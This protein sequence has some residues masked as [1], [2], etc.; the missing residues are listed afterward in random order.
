M[1]GIS[2][3]WFYILQ[4]YYSHWLVMLSFFT[5]LQFL[6]ICYWSKHWHVFVCLIFPQNNYPVELQKI[7][8]M[9]WWHSV[10]LLLGI[11][12]IFYL[13]PASC[14]LDGRLLNRAVSTK[15]QY[16]KMVSI[17]VRQLKSLLCNN[18]DKF[19]E[20]KLIRIQ[21]QFSHSVVSDTLRPHK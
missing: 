5:S 11:I 3:C 6:C 10:E 1:Q 7:H 2:G 17:Q 13:N 18:N 20:Y 12:W 9:E 4:L 19:N 16:H 15:I 8:Q 14:L 21:Y